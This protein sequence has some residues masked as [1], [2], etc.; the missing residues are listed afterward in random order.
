MSCS[1]KL[2]AGDIGVLLGV[3]V[4]QYDEDLQRCVAVD[5]SGA[6]ALSITVRRPAG[7]TYTKT[8]V[9]TGDGTDGQMHFLTAAGDLDEVGPGWYRQGKV[10]FSA[11]VD[12][13]R[14]EAVHFEV[15]PIL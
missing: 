4:M 2:H 14:T 6:T 15:Y 10:V 8:A 13:K 12:E 1:P 3:T 5:I 7:S 9:L 11:G